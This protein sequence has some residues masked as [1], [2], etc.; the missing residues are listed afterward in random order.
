VRVALRRALVGLGLALVL[1]LGGSELYLRTT[2][3]P[4]PDPDTFP[5]VYPPLMTLRVRVTRDLPGL[6]AREVA[7]HASALGLRGG[8]L[9]L[10][11]HD[12]LR[13]LALGDSVTECLLLDDA[14]T[15]PARLEAELAARLGR[16]VWVGN[17]AR[18]GLM[19][20]DYIAHMQLLV[21][22]LA[23][24]LVV[25]LPG[26]HDFQ[27][28]LEGALLPVDLSDAAR[29]AQFRAALYVPA[30]LEGLS[31]SYLGYVSARARASEDLDMTDFYERAR[32]RR[33]RAAKKPELPDLED[34]LDI[35]ASGLDQ[36]ATAQQK[37]APQA[38]LVLLTHPSL[39]RDDLSEAETRA[40]W[41]GYTCLDCDAP[42]FY[43]AP[44]L[45]RGLAQFNAATL[46]L[47]AARGL[48]CLDLAAKI[49][50]TLENFY[51]DA[52]LRE[53]GARKVAEGVADFLVQRGLVQ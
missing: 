29:L 3:H 41:G 49:D 9:D 48:S 14:D 45:A 52:H 12:V 4:P 20:S 22:R 47:C 37:H 39:W 25:I 1:A 40:L 2:L 16:K 28:A 43:A 34:A 51:D 33:A 8:E 19:V 31:A 42:E 53:A 17:A 38:K 10:D 30:N 5:F 46:S 24:D 23:P 15:W 6:P 21:P 26:G 27:A 18:S 36:L 32:T 44:A 13:V 11:D 50:K 35:Y 7:L